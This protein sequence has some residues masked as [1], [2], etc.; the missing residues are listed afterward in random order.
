M[1]K[2]VRDRP[3]ARAFLKDGISAWRSSDLD[4][5]ERVWGAADVPPVGWKVIVGIDEAK[6]L[7]P[8]YAALLRNSLVLALILLLA[9][10]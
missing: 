7:G 9:A 8:I 6:V 5:T 1:G 10:G 2:D 3:F 4:G